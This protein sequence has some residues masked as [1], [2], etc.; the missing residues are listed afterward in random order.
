[1]KKQ[2][3]HDFL[4]KCGGVATVANA[5]GLSSRALYKWTTKDAQPRTE[6]TGE[7]SY[8]EKLADISGVPSVPRT[9]GS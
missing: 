3:L 7:T 8:S 5:L 9:I 2:N 1:M 6:Y 4:I